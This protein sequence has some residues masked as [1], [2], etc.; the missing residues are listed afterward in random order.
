M[1]CYNKYIFLDFLFILLLYTFNVILCESLVLLSYWYEYNVF[2]SNKNKIIFLD[3]LVEKLQYIFILT[4]PT[5]TLDIIDYI[6]ENQ[7]N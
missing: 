5:Q 3:R 2:W 6:K 7:I 4:T 1:L